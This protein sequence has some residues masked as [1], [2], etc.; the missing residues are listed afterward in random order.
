[1]WYKKELQKNALQ[2]KVTEVVCL[3]PITAKKRAE[4]K[5]EE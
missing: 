1:M 4:P 2:Q 5:I 3:L